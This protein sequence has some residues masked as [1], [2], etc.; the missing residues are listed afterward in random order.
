[1]I[2]VCGTERESKIEVCGKPNNFQMQFDA[3]NNEH[4]H[5]R[6]VSLPYVGKQ[7]GK[8]FTLKASNN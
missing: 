4:L 8:P 5:G 1:M 6:S 2:H 3:N 7:I